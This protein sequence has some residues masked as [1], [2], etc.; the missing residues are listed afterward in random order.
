[1]SFSFLNEARRDLFVPRGHVLSALEN[2]DALSGAQAMSGW[3]DWIDEMGHAALDYTIINRVAVIRINGALCS[4]QIPFWFFYGDVTY[5][6]IT[7]TLKHAAGNADVDSIVLRFNSPGGTVV[8]C[9]EA[10]QII[11]KISGMGKPVLA[12]AQMADSAAYW[13]ASATNRIYVDPT[14]EVGSIG[15]ICM[16]ADYSEFYAKI[17]VKVTPLFKGKH[18]ADG[19]SYGPLTEQAQARFD[20]ELS[21]MRDLFAGAVAEYRGMDVNAVRGTEAMTYTGALGVAAGLADEVCFFEDLLAIARDLDV[22]K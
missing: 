6:N 19:H 2:T 14:G 16:H 20:G 8:G 12:H 15:V 10:A 11:D 18:K 4:A 9:A 17:G 5:E 13:L 3:L 1:M 7:E 22:D 21:Y